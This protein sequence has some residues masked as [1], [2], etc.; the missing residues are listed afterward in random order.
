MPNSPTAMTAR[1]EASAMPQRLVTILAFIA[2][3]VETLGF[4]ALFGL[5]VSQVTTN[6]VMLGANL[7]GQGSGILLKLAVL[8]AFVA[9]VGAAKITADFH[10][11]RDGDPERTMYVL[12]GMMLTGMMAAGLVA[13]PIRR[14]DA[15]GVIVSGLFGAVAMGIQHG[16]G[17]LVIAGYPQAAVMTQNVVQAVIDAID[18]VAH[19]DTLT[20][21]RSRARLGNALLPVA[22]FVV[23]AIVAAI[24]YQ[25]ASFW[26]LLFP[27]ILLAILALRASATSCAVGE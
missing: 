22:S 17:R 16:Y 8:P 9:G 23:G 26:T 19:R 1:N 7:T 24:G 3:Y 18:A 13:L 14:P 21:S 25:H 2:G 12:Q 10:V 6:F 4:I 27:I 15:A 11:R 5:F 20:R